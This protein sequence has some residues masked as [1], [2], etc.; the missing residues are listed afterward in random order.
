MIAFTSQELIIYVLFWISIPM[1]LM[2]FV[3][4]YMGK[5]AWIKWISENWWDIH[6]TIWL[7]VFICSA[8]IVY[9]FLKIGQHRGM[10]IEANLEEKKSNGYIQS[11]DTIG[12]LFS[13]ILGIKSVL[14]HGTRYK[15][16]PKLSVMQ[17]SFEDYMGLDSSIW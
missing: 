17:K 9:K 16:F 11:P 7:F 5:D 14:N 10:L 4:D 1:S 6:Y 2:A 15:S 13:N 8:Y 3:Q 12:R